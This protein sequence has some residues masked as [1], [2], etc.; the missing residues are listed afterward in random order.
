MA[1]LDEFYLKDLA[2]TG[3]LLASPSG[4]LQAV[5]G[6]ANM[7]QALFRRLLTVPGSLVHRPNYGVGIK[8]FTNAPNS[9]D[10]QRKI[11]NRIKEQFEQDFRVAEV[12]GVEISNPP[13]FPER[14]TIRTRVRLEGVDEDVNLE[15]KT[16]QEATE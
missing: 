6:V 8:N 3:D 2:H 14:L 10:N 13:T 5:N 15:F 11:A 9:F 7:R 12:V 16:F 4:D 1:L